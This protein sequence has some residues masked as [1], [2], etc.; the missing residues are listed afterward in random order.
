ML[1]IQRRASH[2]P[3]VSYSLTSHFPTQYLHS[4]ITSGSP[5]PSI[6]LNIYWVPAICQVLDKGWGYTE[7]G[8]RCELPGVSDTSA[9][10]ST[11]GQYEIRRYCENRTP[12][13]SW[14]QKQLPE[15]ISWLYHLL[16]QGQVSL[17]CW[18]KLLSGIYLKY[19]F[20][21]GE[22]GGRPEPTN[23]NHWSNSCHRG[24]SLGTSLCMYEFPLKFFLN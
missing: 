17:P 2:C 13:Q 12:T 7:R 21:P 24:S 4:L 22:D 15:I 3:P 10:D 11:A 14:T 9:N 1:G 8:M 6:H 19:S 20:S 23:L 5:S 16:F 18:Q